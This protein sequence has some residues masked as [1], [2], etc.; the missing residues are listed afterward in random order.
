MLNFQRIKLGGSENK[1]WEYWGGGKCPVESPIL[2]Q[3]SEDLTI[4]L[5]KLGADRQAAT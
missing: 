1:F 3:F 2:G 5:P 4:I